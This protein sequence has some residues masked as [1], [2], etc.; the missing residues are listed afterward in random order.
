MIP[1]D[2]FVPD[3]FSLIEKGID[4]YYYLQTRST[5]AIA[6]GKE[7]SRQVVALYEFLRTLYFDVDVLVGPDGPFP[8]GVLPLSA[9]VRA[10]PERLLGSVFLDKPPRS[11]DEPRVVQAIKNRGSTIWNGKTFSLAS[12]D[13]DASGNA[14][15]MHA[16]I[17][18]YF[19]MVDSAV[20]LEYEILAAVHNS[21]HGRPYSIEELP[22]RQA[23]L[24]SFSAPAECLRMGGGVDATIAISTLTVYYRDGEYWMLCEARSSE[25]AEYD[26]LYHVAPSF[27]FQPVMAVTPENLSVEWSIAHNIFRE[28]LEELFNV[29]EVAHSAG[30]VAPDY[31]YGHSNLQFLQQLIATGGATVESVVVA[32]NLLNHRPEICTVLIVRDPYWYS[33]QKDP[34]TA[35]R[36]QLD[37]WLNLNSEFRS[38]EDNEPSARFES[39]RTLRLNDPKWAEIVRPWSMVPPGAPALILGAKAA[40]RTLGLDVP[41]WLQNYSIDS[42]HDEPPGLSDEA[43]DSE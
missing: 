41:P 4:I 28:Y 38:A 22:Q 35:R 32:Y 24:S 18:S 10:S 23:A 2:A 29:P 37:S 8:I 13:L 25:V 14:D 15:K 19:D 17:G 6:A 20:Y 3:I 26:D 16:F 42:G 5:R 27:I 11:V 36:N 43:M 40:C 9:E 33:L 39:V 21:L 1:F 12:I 31:F 30:A 34:F 7:Q